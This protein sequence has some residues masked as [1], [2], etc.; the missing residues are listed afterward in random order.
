MKSKYVH[1][2]S[3]VLMAVIGSIIG[4]SLEW[5]LKFA[6]AGFVWLIVSLL[7]DIRGLLWNRDEAAKDLE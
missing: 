2:Q 3:F 4:S 5:T 1:L 7:M 6:I